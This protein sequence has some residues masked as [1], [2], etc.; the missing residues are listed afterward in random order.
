MGRRLGA[1]QLAVVCS[2][3]VGCLVAGLYVTATGIRESWSAHQ[4]A[5][6]QSAYERELGFHYARMDRALA[7]TAIDWLLL[8]D[9][10]LQAFPT[11]LLPGTAISFAVGGESIE[12][13]I[14]RM[15]T[16]SLSAQA[17]YIVLNG[18]SN[19]LREGRA[20]GDVERSWRLAVEMVRKDRILF[21]VGLMP[22]RHWN[23]E[24]HE[25]RMDLNERIR[26]IC[27]GRGGHFVDMYALL[28]DSGGRLQ[29]E[30]DDGDGVHLTRA[31]YALLAQALRR[32]A[33]LQASSS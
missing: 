26:S 19:D 29:S 13:L 4:W 10:Q 27:V 14:R 2:V 22:Q 25:R 6:A 18:G 23:A 17:R 15:P 12:R 1:K 11:A 21:C 32:Q 5:A 9:S 30:F 7:G 20:V 28:A 24:E 33:T 3:A 31:A 8:G 16:Y